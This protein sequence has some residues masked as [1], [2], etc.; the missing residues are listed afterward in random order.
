MSDDILWVIDIDRKKVRTV[1]KK[2]LLILFHNTYSIDKTCKW[3][4]STRFNEYCYQTLG[5]H[6][7]E[8]NLFF[9]LR[10]H[11]ML[12]LFLNMSN[13]QKKRR[14]QIKFF[15]KLFFE[16]HSLSPWIIVSFG[17]KLMPKPMNMIKVGCTGVFMQFFYIL[18]KV[19]VKN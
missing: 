10:K 15:K 19:A 16:A 7:Q 12:F 6:S 8:T 9:H 13:S 14:F 3:S 11:W 2:Y 5:M 18:K 17:P 4:K 1:K